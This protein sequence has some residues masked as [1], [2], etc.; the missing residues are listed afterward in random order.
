MIAAQSAQ[1]PTCYLAWKAGRLDVDG[2]METRHEGI[3]TRV[4]FQMT[5]DLMWEWVDDFVLV[6]DA[7]IDCAMRLLAEQA[8][9]VAEGAGAVSLAAALQMRER[10][11]GKKVVGILTGGNVPSAD[12]AHL[13][14]SQ[15]S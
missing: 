12:W 10:L 3:A 6:D 2:P 7:E 1:A 15:Q 14:V 5:M 9:L 13:L 8:K 4:P 11:R